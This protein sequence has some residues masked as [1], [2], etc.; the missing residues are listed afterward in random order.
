MRSVTSIQASF[1]LLSSSVLSLACNTAT[2]PTESAAVTGTGGTPSTTTAPAAAAGKGATSVAG[3]V[4]TTPVTGTAGT[5]T[6][7]SPATA[8]AG[9]TA[10]A[11]ASGTGAVP[12]STS[13]GTTAVATAGTGAAAAG[14]GSAAAGSAA[15]A[16][17]A[18]SGGAPAANGGATWTA[19]YDGVIVESGC[20]GGGACHQSPMATSKLGLADP[21]MAYTALVNVA[22]MGMNLP[23]GDMTIANCAGTGTL[24]VK[25][26]DPDSSLLVQKLEGTQKCGMAMP[27]GGMVEDDK[28][29]MVR[30]WIKAGAKMD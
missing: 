12:P 3:S 9:G 30:N 24:R 17:A 25:P 16:P 21:M 15:G 20:V 5:G 28:L 23:G 10:T 4:A 7:A 29:A 6:T 1:V 27:P 2:V 18:G 11:P 26:S 13:A 19:V 8:A 14:S 22:A